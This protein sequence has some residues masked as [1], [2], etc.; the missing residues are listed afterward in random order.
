MYTLATTLLAVIRHIYTMALAHLLLLLTTVRTGPL[1]PPQPTLPTDVIL[2]LVEDD[3][4]EWLEDLVRED[5]KIKEFGENNTIIPKLRTNTTDILDSL[6]QTEL[7][8]FEGDIV[9][10]KLVWGGGKN[11]LLEKTWD[12]G[13]VP[14]VMSRHFR[15][16]ERE[17]VRRAM[18]EIECRTCVQFVERKDE[19]GRG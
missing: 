4:K 6:D 9:G 7:G 12:G 1:F 16:W 17:V 15:E 18:E 10:V 14:Y 11:V 13:V 8:Y 2:T 3:S 19:R 5:N